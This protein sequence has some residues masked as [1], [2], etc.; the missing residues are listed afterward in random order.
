[1]YRLEDE[2]YKLP[3]LYFKGRNNREII[4][5]YL[6]YVFQRETIGAPYQN[7]L[8]TFSMFKKEKTHGV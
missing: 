6:H 5:C 3:L 4:L 2:G 7:Q 1:M 8:I